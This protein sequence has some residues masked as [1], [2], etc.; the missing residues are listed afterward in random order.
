MQGWPANRETWDVDRLGP[1]PT[2]WSNR[3]APDFM[4]GVQTRDGRWWT[5]ASLLNFLWYLAAEFA[6]DWEDV[7]R[8]NFRALPSP[9]DAEGCILPPEWQIRA[10]EARQKMLYKNSNGASDD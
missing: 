5:K 8:S 7:I 10:L 1:S 4:D 3:L 6:D 2:D 9:L